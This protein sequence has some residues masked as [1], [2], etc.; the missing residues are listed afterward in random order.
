VREDLMVPKDL[1]VHQEIRVL[2]ALLETVEY[3]VHQEPPV[4]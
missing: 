2:M 4:K 3:L 1:L